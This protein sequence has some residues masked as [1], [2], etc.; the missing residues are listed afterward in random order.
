MKTKASAGGA[1]AAGGM[2]FQHRVAAW[3]A[4]HILA[5]KGA[6]APWNLPA[7]ASLEWLQCETEQSVDD[8]L[9]GS[10]NDGLV[11][12]QVKRRLE[13]SMNVNSELASSLDQFVRQFIACQS[14]SLG[15]QPMDRPLDPEKDRLVLII[16]PTSSKPIRLHFRDVLDRLRHLPPSY[17]VYEA[18]KNDV[19]H[20]VLSVVKAHVTCFWQKFLKADPSEN[21]FRQILSLIHVQVLDLAE[22]CA[23][24]GEAKNLL[25]NAILRDPER[26]DVAWALLVNLCA[27]FAVQRSGTDRKILQRELLNTGIELQAARSYRPDIERLEKYSNSIF[28]SLAYLARIRIGSK[29]VKIQRPCTEMLRRSAEEKSILVVGE[30]GAGKSGALHN[31]IGGLREDGRDLVFFAV[32]R[33]AAR[34][35]GELRVDIGLNHEFIDVLENWPGSKPAFLVI[36]ALDAAREDPAGR[37]IRD[38]IR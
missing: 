35:L 11:F 25:R 7:D 30:P 16:S 37:M 38:L 20:Q 18:A 6:T 9:V 24:E 3:V 17:T 34:S 22:G 19:D 23:D 28:E 1:A 36:D 2:D 12:A 14:R 32:D 31:L 29:E 5:E 4:V 15:T 33:L 10:S 8:L 13:L 27:G 21:E 26:A